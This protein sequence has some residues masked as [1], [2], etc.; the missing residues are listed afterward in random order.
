[1]YTFSDLTD[2]GDDGPKAENIND[3]ATHGLVLMFQPLA[4]SYIQTAA[5]F[6]SNG[7]VK[8]EELA[9]IVVK[10]MIFLEDCGIKIHSIISDDASTNKKMNTELGVNEKLKNTKNWFVHPNDVTRKVFV[11]SDVSHVIKNIRNRLY[12]KRR[13]KESLKM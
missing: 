9:K 5:V 12:D 8:G 4:S 3:Q 2:F 1:M 11:F 10:G 7:P 6:A 13:L